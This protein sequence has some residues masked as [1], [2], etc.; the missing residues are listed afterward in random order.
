MIYNLAGSQSYGGVISG[1]G[2]VTLAGT[3]MLTLTGSNTFTG[4]ATVSAGT[5]QIGDGTSNGSLSAT[6]GVA[7]NSALVFNVSGGGQQTYN[8]SIS[9]LGNLTQAGSGTLNLGGANTFSGTTM[10]TGGTLNLANS[11]ALQGSTVIAPT[12]GGLSFV[13][14]AFT[15]GGLSGAGNVTLHNTSGSAIALTVGG[16]NGNTTYSGVLS[17][18]GGSLTKAGSG[19]LILTNGNTYTGPTTIA[20]GTLQL[21][22]GSGHDGSLSNLSNINNNASL[23]YALS[24][25]QAYSGTISGMGNLTTLGNNVLILTGTNTYTG[26]TTISGGTLQIG[27]GATNGGLQNTVGIADNSCL[28]F[29]VAT[30]HHAK[31]FQRHQWLRQSDQGRRRGLEAGRGEYLHRRDNGHRWHARSDQPSAFAGE[32]AD[33]RQHCFRFERRVKR[34]FRSAAWAAPEHL[35]AKHRRT[36]IALTVGANNANTT[37]SGILSATGGSLTKAGSGTLILTGANTYGGGT[38]VAGGTLEVTSTSALSHYSTSSV[39]VTGG[40]TLALTV[41]TSG[42]SGREAISAPCFPPIA[43]ISLSSLPLSWRH[44]Q[45]AIFRLA[46]SVAIWG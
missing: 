28:A 9:G 17:A 25:S 21:G 19:T 42:M 45:R 33:D 26:P 35:A 34:L 20:G 36:A 43:A 10:V 6:G 32:Y 18:T 1:S 11:G 39:S 38:W 29:N 22:D 15:F 44:N 37:Y 2:N 5:L 16:N 24:G 4:G 31:L 3:G 40:A 7:N 14:N 46:D 8:G 23:V 12:A 41:G 13:G 30:N 27:D